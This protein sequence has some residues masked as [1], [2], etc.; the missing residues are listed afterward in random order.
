[1]ETFRKGQKIGKIGE[2]GYQGPAAWQ[3]TEEKH[4]TTGGSGGDI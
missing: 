3:D 1:M 2:F 4:Y